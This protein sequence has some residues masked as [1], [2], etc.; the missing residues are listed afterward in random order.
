M[1]FNQIY[2]VKDVSLIITRMVIYFLLQY[3]CHW[4]VQVTVFMNIY[5]KLTCSL[6]ELIFG[7]NSYT[8][9]PCRCVS[10]N[11]PTLFMLCQNWVILQLVLVWG[12][13]QLQTSWLSSVFSSLYH[14]VLMLL[15]FG[16]AD[17]AIQ[18]LVLLHGDITKITHHG[19]AKPG[20]SLSYGGIVLSFSQLVTSTIWLSGKKH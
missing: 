18:A 13:Q 14:L 2:I 11:L 3:M 7:L 10:R 20:F 19:S 16:I 8:L 4:A 17:A 1:I 6:V 5:I 12:V 15:E 9:M